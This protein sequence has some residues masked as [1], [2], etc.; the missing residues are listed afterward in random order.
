MG[1]VNAVDFDRFPKQGTWLGRTVTVCFN[2]D[3]SKTLSGII[4]RED[5][6]SPGLMII[7]LENGR[8]VLSTECQYRLV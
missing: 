4:V 2:Y 7:Q 3:T 5:V 8:Y 1:C 6:D